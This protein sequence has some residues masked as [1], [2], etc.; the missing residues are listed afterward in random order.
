MIIEIL[1]SAPLRSVQ[2]FDRTLRFAAREPSAERKDFF[3]MLTQR[4]PLQR[5]GAR[6]GPHWA[7]LCR[8]YGAGACWALGY[9]LSMAHCNGTKAFSE[10]A[11]TLFNQTQGPYPLLALMSARARLT[12]VGT[13]F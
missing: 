13:S 4:L 9:R 5:A 12:R 7:N 10:I 8:A 2:D 1:D 3:S 6:L 11:Q